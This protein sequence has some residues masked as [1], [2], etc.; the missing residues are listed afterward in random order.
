[1]LEIEN[2]RCSLPLNSQDE[3]LFPLG[4][5]IS[6]NIRNPIEFENFGTQQPS[7]LILVLT[8]CGYLASFFVINRQSKNS[9]CYEPKMMQL[10][11]YN[12]TKKGAFFY[13]NL[14]LHFFIFKKN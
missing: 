6:Y 9:I 14:K 4:L 10:K 1:V 3:E 7:P 13:S 5:S 12:T 11:C 2:Y 8:D